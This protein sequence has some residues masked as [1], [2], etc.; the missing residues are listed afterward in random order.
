LLPLR[1]DFDLKRW[2]FQTSFM[3]RDDGKPDAKAE[4]SVQKISSKVGDGKFS[5]PDLPPEL[6]T[7]PKPSSP[8]KRAAQIV[9]RP[10]RRVLRVCDEG[11]GVSEGNLPRL[12]EPFFREG[13][14]RT[15]A[16]SA[17]S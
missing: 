2:N 17:W 5:A 16:A 3:L 10:E 4:K 9:S 7:L 15:T 13:E 14:A 6:L 8:H 12:F 11:A 1:A